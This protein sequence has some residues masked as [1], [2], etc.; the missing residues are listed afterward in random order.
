VL[1]L[2]RPVAHETSLDGS[3][4][5]ISLSEPAVAQTARRA[6]AHF[7][8]GKGEAGTPSATS[9]SAAPR[10]RGP[11]GGRSL[12]TSTGIDIASRARTSSSS[13]SRPRF[14]HLRG[15]ST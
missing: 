2:R 3:A 5:V 13:S 6:V 14:P 9:T 15:R 10:R 8:E 11:R 12:D 7:A 4:L 1:N